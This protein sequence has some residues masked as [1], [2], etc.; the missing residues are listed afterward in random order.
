RSLQQ[1]LT[2]KILLYTSVIL[3]FTSLLSTYIA[4][5]EAREIQDNFLQQVSVMV[6]HD[7]IKK[8]LSL[9]LAV[10]D[11]DDDDDEAIHIQ[12]ISSLEKEPFFSVHIDIKD[13]FHTLMFHQIKWRLFVTTNASNSTSNGQ[14]FLVAQ[15]TAFRDEMAMDAGLNVLFPVIAIISVLFVLLKFIINQQFQPVNAL[16]HQIQRQEASNLEPLTTSDVPSELLPFINAINHLLIQV[17]QSITKQQRFI[18]DASHEL[19]TPVTAL[20]LMVDNIANAS[21]ESKRFERHLQLKESIVRMQNLLNQLLDLARLQSNKQNPK[22]PVLLNDMVQQVVADLYPLAEAN[23]VDLGVA[24][25]E[26]IKVFDQ[27]N[28]LHQLMRNAIHNAIQYSPAG[29][30]VNIRLYKQDNTAVFQVEDNGCGI[31]EKM[32]TKV[33]EPFYRNRD[34]VKSGTG[35]GLAIC[36]EIAQRLGGKIQLENRKEGGLIFRYI[37]TFTVDNQTGL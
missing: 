16:I 36:Y 34:I 29:E 7:L 8:N 10:K 19:R 32:L 15:Q 14:R 11:E 24:Q 17:R 6:K 31:P 23:H 20:S 12:S 5:D 21:T 33:F 4:Y 28:Y 9:V 2:Q 3:I 18:A 35:L 25:L 1:E 27:D 30:Q 22:T 26:N 13:G 37:Q